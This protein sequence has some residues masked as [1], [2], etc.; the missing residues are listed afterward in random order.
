M[1]RGMGWGSPARLSR[2]S[3]DPPGKGGEGR[4]TAL[5]PGQGL[6]A[7]LWGSGRVVE[8][9]LGEGSVRARAA[10]HGPQRSGPAGPHTPR[11]RAPGAALHVLVLQAPH[12]FRG[13]IGPGV[14]CLQ[15][16]C[17]PLASLEEC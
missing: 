13:Y 8:A 2:A 4:V 6:R 3:P 14:V 10:P 5:L 7:E 9:G 12:L 17:S 11:E 16:V 15:R 1:P